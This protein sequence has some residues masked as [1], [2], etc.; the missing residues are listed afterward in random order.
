MTASYRIEWKRSAAK[1][2]KK[3]ERGDISAIV[4][5]V[6]ELTEDPYPP[7]SRKLKGS[8]QSYRIR[9]GDYRVLYSIRPEVLTVDIIRV[10]HRKDIYRRFILP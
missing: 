8:A 2:L 4:K 7:G 5:A 3:L 1:E 6:E 10:G 9:I